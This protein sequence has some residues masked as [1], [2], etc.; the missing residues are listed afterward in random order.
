MNIE[1]LNIDLFEKLSLAMAIIR[2]TP[3]GIEPDVF[4]RCLA[5]RLVS[6]DEQYHS[7]IDEYLIFRQE[8]LLSR[9][10]PVRSTI[11]SSLS[12]MDI[13][14]ELHRNSIKNEYEYGEFAEKICKLKEKTYRMKIDDIE[15][16]LTTIT[17][18]LINDF[19]HRALPIDACLYTIHLIATNLK[20]D[21]DKPYHI[22]LDLLPM[23][24]KFLDCLLDLLERTSENHFFHLH[25]MVVSLGE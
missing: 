11:P 14:N 18:W 16:L 1:I 2:N 22:V 4:T 21:N 15:F 6:R 13:N 17:K 3:S 23:I 19:D 10:D 9:L 8:D 20:T 7:L 24:D 5:R 25:Q 12:L